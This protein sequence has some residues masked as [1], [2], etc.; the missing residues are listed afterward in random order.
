MT[1][2]NGAP[3]ALHQGR[4]DMFMDI[5]RMVNEGLGGG[6]VTSENGLIE[7]STTGTM[8]F[9]ESVAQDAAPLEKDEGG[10]AD[11]SGSRE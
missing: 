11:G 6:L 8:D 1:D 7:E 9:P 10:S 4:D 2:N 5:D 3:D